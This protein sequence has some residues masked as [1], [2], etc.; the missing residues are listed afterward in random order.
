MVLLDAARANTKSLVGTASNLSRCE[1]VLRAGLPFGLD[2]ETLMCET[3][4]AQGHS[5]WQHSTAAR[6][7][8]RSL[9]QLGC[10]VGGGIKAP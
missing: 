7:G 9:L 3:G 6:D 10:A 1:R 4:F 8:E 2:V 5:A